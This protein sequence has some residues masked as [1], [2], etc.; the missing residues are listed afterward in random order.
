[1]GSKGGKNDWLVGQCEVLEHI[2]VTLNQPQGNNMTA[3]R[4]I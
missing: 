4:P 1:M 2:S 3:H